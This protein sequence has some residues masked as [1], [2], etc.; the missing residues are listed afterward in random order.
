MNWRDKR[1]WALLVALL[2]VGAAWAMREWDRRREAQVGG[3]TFQVRDRGEISKALSSSM[4]VMIDF[5]SEY[6]GP[7]REMAPELIKAERLLR[8]KVRVIFADVWEDQSLAEGFPLRVIP[9]QFFF[10]P[11]GVPM[12]APKGNPLGLVEHRSQDGRH[13]F[14][15]HEGP[16][17]AEEIVGLFRQAGV[18]VD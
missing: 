1:L 18:S 17:S 7:C 16:L 4:P 8:G 3:F 2:V 15:F 6:C 13:L 10:L 11:K 12:R 9:T 5:G 14:T